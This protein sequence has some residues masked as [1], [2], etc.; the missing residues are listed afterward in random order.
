MDKVLR[1]NA[2]LSATIQAHIQLRA[3]TSA[4][5]QTLEQILEA[6]EEPIQA[7]IRMCLRPHLENYQGEIERMFQEHKDSLR[8]RVWDKLDL[9]LEMTEMIVAWIQGLDRAEQG[10]AGS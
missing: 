3:Q 9:T 7:R 8:K 6:L 10:A 4:P 5:P 2:A 1:E